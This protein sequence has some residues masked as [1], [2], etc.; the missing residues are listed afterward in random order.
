MPA[1]G[2]SKPVLSIAVLTDQPTPT[3]LN[4]GAAL[5]DG[6]HAAQVEGEP[7]IFAISDGDFGVLNASTLQLVPAAL[8]PTNAPAATPPATNS[9]AQ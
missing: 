2:L 1:Y 8:S 3:I 9:P 5:P 4:I 7:T 6:T